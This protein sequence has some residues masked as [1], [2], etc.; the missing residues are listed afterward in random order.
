MDKSFFKTSFSQNTLGGRG[1]GCLCKTHQRTEISEAVISNFSV[2]RIFLKFL[3]NSREN[4][5]PLTTILKMFPISLKNSFSRN[6]RC[7]GESRAPATSNTEQF[8]TTV[9]GCQPLVTIAKTSSILAVE[10][11]LDPPPYADILH[12]VLQIPNIL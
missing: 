4:I 2:E 1:G 5:Q 12:Q 6:C 11:A 7:R 8:V 9:H 10:A 3:E